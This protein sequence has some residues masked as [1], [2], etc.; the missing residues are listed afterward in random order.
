M[1]REPGITQDQVNQAAN[2]LRDSG[3]TPTARAIREALGTG[4]M[5]TVL[6]ML[7]LWQSGQV[8]QAEA[9]VSLPP[10]LQRGLL[11]FVAGEVER[12][13]T[14][15]LVE[16]DTAKQEASDL[17]LESERL[18]LQ[19]QT[20]EAALEAVYAEK[21]ELQ[22]RQEQIA[23]ERD[24]AR[25]EAV[26][27]RQ[28]AES[29][30]TELAKA[31]LRLEAMPRLEADLNKVHATVDSER[32]ARVAAEQAS[33]VDRARLE[34]A[35]DARAM[36]ERALADVQK[37]LEERNVA[38]AASRSEVIDGRRELRQAHE[39]LEKEKEKEK[40]ARAPRR[41]LAQRAVVDKPVTAKK[42]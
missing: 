1:A 38:L 4:S 8:K 37:Q 18:A 36:V 34:G 28:A 35:N 6:R 22:G 10:A 27:E 33:A 31:L 7:Q 29:T 26:A 39:A 32:K 14:G 19:V 41:K 13:R 12:N 20:L 16:L 40:H 30:R 17:I 21:A 2:S 42:P 25:Q 23:V 15:L 9:T 24:T 3:V 5:A 11:D